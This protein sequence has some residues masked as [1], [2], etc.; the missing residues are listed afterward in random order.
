MRGYMFK[1]RIGALVFVGLAMIGAANLVGTE[2]Q[3]GAIQRAAAELQDQ[4]DAFEREIQ[5]AAPAETKRA[6]PREVIEVAASEED[7]IDDA[8]GIDP[9]GT[10]PSGFDPTPRIE[11]P[12]LPV[13][14][15]GEPTLFVENATEE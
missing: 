12:A 6:K 2:E 9:A 10:D 4:R 3:D 5:A 13:D 8:Q 15:L 1:N 11:R 14:Q 7:L